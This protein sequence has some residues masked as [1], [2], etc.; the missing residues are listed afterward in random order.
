MKTMLMVAALVFAVQGEKKSNPGFDLIKK[1]E[2]SWESTDKEHPCKGTYKP[3]SGGSI[4]IESMAMGNHAE[5]VTIYHPDGDGLGMTHY[6]MLGNQPHMRAATDSKPGT[7]R[8][9]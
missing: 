8:L 2:G 6:C 9:A 4:V 3:S 5:M 7:P 1:L